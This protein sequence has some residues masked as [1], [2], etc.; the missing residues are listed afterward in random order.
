MIKAIFTCIALASATANAGQYTPTDVTIFDSP[1]D[2]QTASGS[3]YGARIGAGNQK[4]ECGL[5]IQNNNSSPSVLCSAEDK[6]GRTLSCTTAD[7]GYVMV[8]QGIT[9]HSLVTFT[10]S[11]TG[12]CEGLYITNG[13]RFLPEV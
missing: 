1:G 10:S 11:R 4:I 8:V 7:L 3:F 9:S 5:S 2:T 13:S 12:V 6:D